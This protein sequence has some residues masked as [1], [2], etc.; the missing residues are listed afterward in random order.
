[1]QLHCCF[2][3]DKGNEFY[4]TPPPPP[5]PPPNPIIYI[6]CKDNISQ[7][8]NYFWGWWNSVDVH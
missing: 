4:D 8:L 6:F 7:K 2:L 3:R 5:P 1:M